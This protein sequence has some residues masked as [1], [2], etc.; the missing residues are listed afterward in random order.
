MDIFAKLGIDWKLLIAQAVNFVILFWVLK[1]FAYKPMLDFLE[2]RAG[3]IEQGL[4]DAEA[5][6]EKLVAVA[7]DEQAI[8]K[9]AREEARAVIARAETDAKERATR[10]DQETEEKVGKLL[11]DA[12]L[13]IEEERKKSLAEAKGEI[14]ALVSQSLEKILREKV[15][16]EKDK[17][18]IAELVRK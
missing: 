4:K 9:T 15:D 8:L 13:Q 16:S 14:A 10:R 17:A 2:G 7:K 6:K 1:R 12:R 5:A 11:A 3:R 18:L